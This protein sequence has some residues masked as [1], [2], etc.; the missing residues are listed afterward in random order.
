MTH[1]RLTCRNW[2]VVVAR[3]RR[4]RRGLVVN[5]LRLLDVHR[6]R[7]NVNRLLNV[8]RRLGVGDDRPH[9]RGADHATQDGCAPTVPTTGLSLPRNSEY[10]QEHDGYFCS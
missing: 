3:R 6:L 5:R 8:N 9:Y 2:L 7:L 1:K 4:W 10:T